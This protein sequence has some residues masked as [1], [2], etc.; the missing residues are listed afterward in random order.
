M[1]EFHV[2]SLKLVIWNKSGKLF[3][4]IS[5]ILEFNRNFVLPHPSVKGW[6]GRE[7]GFDVAWSWC[8][9]SGGRENGLVLPGP[10]VKTYWVWWKR[11]WIGVAWS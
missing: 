8:K 10:S 5:L 4:V 11:K 7:N 6:S 9:G 2:L 1:I 3:H